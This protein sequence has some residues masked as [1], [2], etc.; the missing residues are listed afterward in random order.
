MFKMIIGVVVMSIIVIAA[1]SFLDYGSNVLNNTSTTLQPGNENAINVT[2]S[3]E[4]VRPGTF[5]IEKGSTLQTLIDTAGGVTS[6]ADE[7]AYNVS[8]S[9]VDN[10][11]YYI[12]PL[13]DLADICGDKPLV[14]YNIN[15][16]SESELLLINGVK[17]NVAANIVTYRLSNPFDCIE[18]LKEVSYI[19]TATF[20]QMKNYVTL[21]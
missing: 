13:Y 15:A 8:F 16:A 3:G 11:S 21:R 4:V 5:I 2:I 6:N 20:E 12:A 7:L 9:L 10:Q 19:G 1:L 18:E 17:S 14:K